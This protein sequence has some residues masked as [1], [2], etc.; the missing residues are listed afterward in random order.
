MSVD[1]GTIYSGV[2]VKLDAL[3]RDVKSV[4][5]EFDKIGGAVSGVNNTV[6]ATSSSFLKLA[7]TF[8]T[9]QLAAQGVSKAMG[10]VVDFTK[11]AITASI[12]AQETFSKYD[13]VFEGM[14]DQSE[15]AAQRFAKAFDLAGVTAKDMLSNTGN[16]LQGFGATK[17]ESLEMA[18]AV[19]TLASD[20]ASFT[21]YS[22][23]AKGASEA[24]TKALL[25][26]RESAKGLGIAILESD[27]QVE[28]ARK[29]QQGLTGE[30]L[31]LAK[32][33]A[34][35]EIITRQAKNSIGDY[36]RTSDSA[37]NTLKRAKESTLELKVALGTQ[38]NPATTLAADLWERVASALADS[39]NKSKELKDA[40]NAEKE[41]N[42]TLDQRIL[43]LQEE[44]RVGDEVLKQ[45]NMT[46]ES[47]KLSDNDIVKSALEQ[48]N[49][50][51][52]RLNKTKEYNNALKAQREE[53]AKG[54][55]AAA[56]ARMEQVK[57]EQEAAD[58]VAEQIKGRKE[59]QEEYDSAL[60]K[61]SY[62]LSKNLITEEE[63]NKANLD[64]AR[65]YID[66]LYKLGYAS[67]S[68]I[69]TIGYNALQSIIEKYPELI[70]LTKE[71]KYETESFGLGFE[72]LAKIQQEFV[73]TGIDGFNSVFYAM[74]EAIATGEDV[75]GAFAKSGL[76]AIASII[77]AIGGQL[78]AQAALSIA[79]AWSTG[80]FSLTGAGPALAGSAAAYTTAGLIRGWAGTFETGGI[81]PGT[82][83][84]GDNMLASVNSGEMILNQQQQARL[85]N[86]LSG[87]R[88][89]ANSGNITVVSVLDGKK[90]S[91]SVTRRQR[92]N[93]A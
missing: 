72:E 51:E 14:G 18:E 66:A 31:K 58:R 32:A 90:V 69:G 7:G 81:V 21:N 41:G 2:R 88:N 38:L 64:A 77:E 53:G 15:E 55:S 9:G 84:S 33:Q 67:E 68:E 48:I 86:E 6:K 3:N 22:G 27:V 54:T 46:R 63:A 19:N 24:L 29:G 34:T 35:L 8:A 28:L 43:L 89:G 13:T 11:E 37:S 26:E 1:A 62:S 44:I 56:K 17:R 20:L 36:A 83:Y 40:R 70:A 65:N 73:Q 93:N 74:A 16:L 42:Q 45:F 80:G 61:T 92:T 52:L 87:L 76:N 25:G 78:A 75:W 59:A 91:R 5:A 50:A 12:D 60:N 85:W 23:G 82:S 4:Q 10:A 39:I 57:L 71:A 30:A 47:A 79:S 49:L